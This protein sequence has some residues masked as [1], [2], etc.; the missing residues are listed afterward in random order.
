MV[1]CLEPSV[2]RPMPIAMTDGTFPIATGVLKALVRWQIAES[3]ADGSRDFGSHT[4]CLVSECLA[5]R[6]SERVR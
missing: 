1:P 6:S 4:T 5:R 3:V 2:V